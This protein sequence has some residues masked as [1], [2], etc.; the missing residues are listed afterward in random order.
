MFVSVNKLNYGSQ[1][2]DN[3]KQEELSMENILVQRNQNL[4][5]NIYDSKGSN[6]QVCLAV[7]IRL[8][9]AK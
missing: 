9:V 5:D 3:Y 7:N 1:F 8:S 2:E 6:N 4:H